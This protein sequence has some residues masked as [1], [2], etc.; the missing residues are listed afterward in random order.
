MFNNLLLQSLVNVESHD[1]Y[2]D[3]LI[4]TVSSG[5]SYVALLLQVAQKVSH[6][7]ESY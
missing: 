2:D 5:H 4:T 6:Y 3:R 7:Y 1:F